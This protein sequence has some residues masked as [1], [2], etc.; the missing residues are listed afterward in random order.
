MENCTHLANQSESELVSGM[1]LK[2]R[3]CQSITYLA[4]R[5]LRFL[6]RSHFRVKRSRVATV[7][8]YPLLKGGM[9]ALVRLMYRESDAAEDLVGKGQD[10]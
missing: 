8:G 4:F 9:M 6:C 1:S 3:T 5:E 10:L 7:V 2:M